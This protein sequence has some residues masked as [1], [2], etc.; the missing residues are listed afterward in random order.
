MENGK[1]LE[2]IYETAKHSQGSAMAEQIT[3]MSSLKGK[4]NELHQNIKGIFLDIGNTDLLKGMIS[5]INSGVSGLR[6]LIQHF[7]SLNTIV[8]V[9]TFSLTAMNSQFRKM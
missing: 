2:K 9:L 7:G 8:G 1:D 4:L 6:F 3:Y 5:G